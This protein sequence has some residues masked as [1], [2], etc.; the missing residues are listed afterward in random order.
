MRLVSGERLDMQ[1]AA[2]DT[3]PIRCA[4]APS[5]HSDMRIILF[6]ARQRE[7]QRVHLVANPSTDIRQN[8][9]LQ[10]ALA[11]REVVRWMSLTPEPLQ[12]PGVPA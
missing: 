6:I 10:M 3:V 12:L 5:N 2:G 9:D 11:S 4:G 8:L 7:Q 1:V